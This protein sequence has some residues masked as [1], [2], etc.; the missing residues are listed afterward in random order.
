MTVPDVVDAQAILG[1]AVAQESLVRT[2]PLGDGALEVGQVA[3]CATAT[4]LGLV[5]HRDVDHPVRGLDLDRPDL[6]G[7]EDAE[8][9][10][11]DH[12]RPAHADVRVL[13]VAITTSQQ[14]SSAAF[15]AKQRPE[16]IPT[17]GTSP[18]R[19]PK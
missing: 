5:R 2:V 3:S 11:L 14:P 16:L 9:S 7:P 18:L 1:D 17:S 15:P 10:A 19:R 12:R 13:A 4:G 6:L 8:T